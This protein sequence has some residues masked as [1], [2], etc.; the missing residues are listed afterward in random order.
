M[1]NFAAAPVAVVPSS[2]C[3]DDG[4]EWDAEGRCPRCNLER[5]EVDALLGA[6]CVDY[7]F[8]RDLAREGRYAEAIAYAEMARNKG[9]AHPA[10][11][12]LLALC[13]AASGRWESLTVADLPAEGVPPLEDI[14]RLYETACEEARAARWPDA[15]RQAEECL[16][17]APWLLPA[18]KLYLLCLQGRGQ[19]DEYPQSLNA[20]LALAPGDK[21][22]VRWKSAAA[23]LSFASQ[24]V[25]VVP[26]S[27]RPSKRF[28]FAGSALV[29]AA[30]LLGV[31]LGQ[32]LNFG[33][34]PSAP[35]SAVVQS[36][37]AF[38]PPVPAPA[39]PA[40][41]IPAPAHHFLSI[42]TASVKTASVKTASDAL[43]DD[44]ARQ[45][46]QSRR[47]ADLRQAHR[48]LR[49]AYQA[50]SANDYPRALRLADAAAHLVQG[51]YLAAAASRLSVRVSREAR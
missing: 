26:I 3:P 46:A 12:R 24:P 44:L 27:S 13:L 29:A 51:S 36:V 7:D 49:S 28:G 20:A 11:S 33:R 23:P 47:R 35:M 18:R 1:P 31:V 2:H 41:A 30:L 43:P 16:V 25:A 45:V 9:L 19:M 5:F 21:D 42:K 37:P 48:W 50:D 14:Q 4:I 32:Y 22:L 10:L 15:L 38:V 34:A 8:A 6:A 39:I 17:L 40:P